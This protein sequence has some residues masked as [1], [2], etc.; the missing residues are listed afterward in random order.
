MARDHCK[1]QW[2][3]YAA[4]PSATDSIWCHCSCENSIIQPPT[5]IHPTQYFD[6]FLFIHFD[7]RSRSSRQQTVSVSLGSRHVYMSLPLTSMESKIVGPGTKQTRRLSDSRAQRHTDSPNHWLFVSPTLWI[8]GSSSHRLIGSST[9][10]LS[11]PPLADSPVSPALL[12]RHMS[13]NAVHW[14]KFNLPILNLC[15]TGQWPLIVLNHETEHLLSDIRC[16]RPWPC[17]CR[18]F[19]CVFFGLRCMKNLIG[20][21]NFFCL[22]FTLHLK[23]C[24]MENWCFCLEARHNSICRNGLYWVPLCCGEILRC[25][26]SVSCRYFLWISESC[27]FRRWACLF[28]HIKE[29]REAL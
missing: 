6:G 27:V 13:L 12:S 19:H 3:L 26:V 14:N 20:K 23:T 25:L 2:L 11:G 7:F 1:W 17:C 29:P 10:R 16:L 8:T 22:P 9:L 5:Y 18:Y 15:A 24:T 21:L 28:N 4:V